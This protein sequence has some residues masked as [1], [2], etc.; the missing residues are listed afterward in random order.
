MA[1]IRPNASILWIYDMT[2]IRINTAPDAPPYQC[3][4]E[5]PK[6]RDRAVPR[7]RLYEYIVRSSI[8]GQRK[9]STICH[10]ERKSRCVGAYL[11]RHRHREKCPV[12]AATGQ[13][14]VDP[15]RARNRFAANESGVWCGNGKE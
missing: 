7:S 3:Q 4:T 12:H 1:K 11:L 6:D 15:T 8:K 9:T 10:W 14:S 13:T 5:T 2:I